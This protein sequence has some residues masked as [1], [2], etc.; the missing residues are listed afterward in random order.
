MKRPFLVF[1]A[2]V[3]FALTGCQTKHVAY[4]STANVPYLTS[5]TLTDM[6]LVGKKADGIDRKYRVMTATDNQRVQYAVLAPDKGAS[7]GYKL[8]DAD[9]N[10][11]VPLK[12][13]TLQA[14]IE[15]VEETLRVWDQKRGER[16]GTFYEFLH[17]PEQD[18][19]SVSDNVVTWDPAIRFTSSHTS[20]GPTVR[21]ILGDSPKD[22]LQRL[23]E[24][25]RREEV[26]DLRDLLQA[27]YDR[28]QS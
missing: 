22:K 18:V 5:S 19:R 25:N 14:L 26:A 7:V 27:A 16:K 4:H 15:G 13:K 20:E 8:K 11:S 2:L 6:V 17:A 12:E 1:A 24:F 9:F 3:A 28:I 23:I 21:I 10:R